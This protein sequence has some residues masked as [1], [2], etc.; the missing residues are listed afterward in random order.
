MTGPHGISRTITISAILWTEVNQKS[1]SVVQDFY[2]RERTLPQRL[3]SS[4]RSAARRGEN[5]R[6]WMLLR[7]VAGVE[8]GTRRFRKGVT[9]LSGV[10]GSE[11]ALPERTFSHRSSRIIRCSSRDVS[12]GDVEGVVVKLFRELPAFNLPILD[13]VAEPRPVGGTCQLEI[14]RQEPPIE[15]LVVGQDPFHMGMT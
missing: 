3:P 15:R 14:G 1:N 8:A 6:R 7:R 2:R 5:G 11:S 12:L 9:P 10:T 13:D 4:H